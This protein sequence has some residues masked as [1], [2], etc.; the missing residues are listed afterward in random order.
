MLR[1]RLAAARLLTLLVLGLVSTTPV[2]QQTYPSRPIRWVTPFSPGGSTTKVSQLV[3]QKLT[4]SW[5]QNVIIDNRAGG[6]TIIGTELVARSAPDG[7][8]ILFQG[9]GVI[10]VTLTHKTPYDLFKDFTP[11]TTITATNYILVVNPSMPAQ[12][13]KQFIAYAKAR[14]G[15]LNVA[16]VASGSSQHLMGELFGILAGVKL[17]HIPYKGGAAGILDLI[18]GRVQ[19][20]FSNAINVI[21]FINA[22]KLKGLAI[23]GDERIASIPDVPTYT[24]AGL[25]S[26]QPKNWQGILAPARTPQAIVVK[27]ANEVRKIVAMPDIVKAFDEGGM[28]PFPTT[29]TQMA[30]EMRIARAQYLNVIKIANLKFDN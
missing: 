1:S 20:S 2:A 25:P 13:L 14:P 28:K 23:T 9:S 17:Q 15:E 16:S 18:A 30:E 7:Y 26:Y 24:E 3:G 8:T 5:G 19:V 10:P 12:N 6:D 22:G 4:E 29:P 21:P 27:I 11:I